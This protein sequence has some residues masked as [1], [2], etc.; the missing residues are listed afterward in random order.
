MKT[1]RLQT[2]GRINR[3]THLNMTFDGRS[4]KAHPGDTLA[5]ALLANGETV[6]ARSFKYHR[7]R[8]ILTAGVEEPNA[9][10]RLRSGARTEPNTPA[11]TTAAYEGLE[12][13]GQNA[14]PNVRFDLNAVNQLFSTFLSAGF[15]YKTFIG[16]FRGTG[17]WMWCEK[18]IRRAAGMGQAGKLED[19]D[20]YEKVNAYCDVLVIGAGPAGLSA[21]LAAGRTGARVMLMEQDIEPGGSILSDPIGSSADL[22]LYDMKAALGTLKNVQILSRATV[23]GAYDQDVYGIVERVWDHVLTPPVNQP[24][25]RYWQVRTKQAVLATGAIERPL[26]FTNNDLPGVMLAG[27]VRTYLNR[28]AILPGQNIVVVTNNDSAYATALELANTGASVTLLD[29]R[30]QIPKALSRALKTTGVELLSSHGVMAAKGRVCVSAV[31]IM[32]IASDGRA[33]G[34]IRQIPCDLLAISGG[35]SPVVNLWSQR[36]QKPIFDTKKVCF[37]PIESALPSMKCAGDIRAA[38]GLVD[39]LEQGFMAGKVAA[40]DAG[41]TGSPGK[42]LIAP[43]PK[44]G[45]NKYRDVQAVWSMSGKNGEI[46]GKAFIDFQHDV[47]TS[48]VDLAHREGYVSVEHLKRYTTMGMATDQGKLSNVNA[49][50]RMAALQKATIPD[51]GTTIFRPPYTPITIG[52]VAGHKIGRHFSPT[53]LTPIHDWHVAKGATMTEAGAWLR[54]RFYPQDGES[55]R[56]AYIR[57]ASHVRS[58]VGLVDVSTL[59]KIAVQGPDAAEFLNRIYVNS[60]KMLAIGRLR[61]GLMLREDGFVMDDGATARLGEF[62]YFMSTTTAA[63]AR[64]LA[65]AEKLLQTSWKD[66]KVHVTSISDQWA[67]IA[68]AGPKS[69]ELLMAAS[70]GGDLSRDAL[71]NNYF[72]HA[73]IAGA[74]VRIHRMSY[75]G[76]L[77]YEVYVEAGFAHFVWEELIKAGEPMHLCP[78]GTEAMGA[79]RIEKGHVAG[80]ELDGRTTMRDL[81][82]DGFA[83]SKK[84]FVGS[85]LKNR[86][87]LIDPAR[88]SL[89]GLD[90]EG[91]EEAKSG[92]LLYPEQGPAKGHGDG[93]V[94]SATYSPA[95][96][97]NIALGLLSNGHERMGERIR[98]VNFVGGTRQTAKVVSPHF[99][100]PEGER[101]NA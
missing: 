73:K 94:S 53:R 54:P 63:A 15:Y 75:S 1:R 17:Y 87:L 37:V 51:T 38:G 91:D 89:V 26:I 56:E 46:Q 27:A 41:A 36:Q 39:T 18:F 67:A 23:F 40:K 14:W 82:M 57:E 68:V 69:R 11:T 77:A 76:E 5:S 49:L 66:L 98:I 12:A 8:G 81:R 96:G 7:P 93:W 2:G 100:D 20:N 70:K 6:V 65:F 28:Y 22:W 74:T 13:F 62:D 30:T 92:S 86:P 3:A 80:P 78:Y 42:P 72:S 59:G 84:P 16:P 52:A 32:R 88:P 45:D 97:K 43:E 48:D 4:L 35:W 99:Y 34:T 47:K 61:Y 9:L 55:L 85:V 33:T 24:R 95:L 71:P 50:A 101:Q 29:A 79:L 21:A 10:L 25:Q 44:I 60:W 64:V 31:D 83:S 19:P 90:I 58:D